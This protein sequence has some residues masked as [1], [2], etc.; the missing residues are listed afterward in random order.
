MK[1]YLYSLYN[2]L[3]GFYENPMADIVEPKDY[4]QYMA[5][6]LVYADIPALTRYK[7]CDLVCLGSID[8]KTGVIVSNVEVLCSLEQVCSDLI[9]TKLLKESVE[10]GKGKQEGSQEASC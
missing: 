5:Q 9:N 7:E 8:N 1:K 6:S 10:N 4:A 2:R 3:G